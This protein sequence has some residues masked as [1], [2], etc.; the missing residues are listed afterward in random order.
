MARSA[1]TTPDQRGLLAG[2]LVVLPLSTMDG[3]VDEV[4]LINRRW[5]VMLDSHQ[6]RMPYV[7]IS[8]VDFGGFFV[9]MEGERVSFR[10]RNIGSLSDMDV[11]RMVVSLNIKE[12]KIITKISNFTYP[13]CLLYN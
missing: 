11:L 10:A 4:G 1:W 3:H 2:F 13:R 7:R 9:T 8:I 12:N 6:F 5:F